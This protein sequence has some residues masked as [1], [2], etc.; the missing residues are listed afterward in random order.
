MLAYPSSI[1]LSTRILRFLSG[2]LAA[3]R[4]DIGTRW[5]QLPAARQALLALAH[6]KV[7]RYQLAAGFGIGDATP[8]PTAAYV[9]PSR[10]CPP[11]SRP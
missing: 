7:R 3:R 5:R 6:L 1:D 10:S 11:S 4:R 9:K 2:Q 8:P